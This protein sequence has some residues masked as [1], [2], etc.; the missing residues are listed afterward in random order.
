MARGWA[1]TREPG[2][3]TRSSNS[4][5]RRPGLRRVSD[6]GYD[7]PPAQGE[8]VQ[9]H[10]QARCRH[11]ACGRRHRPRGYRARGRV[12]GRSPWRTHPAN[13]WG[14]TTTRRL[15]PRPIYTAHG[16]ERPPTGPRPTG[17]ECLA[18]AHGARSAGRRAAVLAGRG[19][20]QPDSRRVEVSA[21]PTAA[22]GREHALAAA[23]RAYSS[24]PRTTWPSIHS[25]VRW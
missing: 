14:A 13:R 23:T 24:M 25:H 17:A 15:L 5:D 1:R 6:S 21:S 4:H 22:H 9:R 16:E 18:L 19:Q 20:R 8:V 3:V 10:S 11:V 2:C 12:R 7:D